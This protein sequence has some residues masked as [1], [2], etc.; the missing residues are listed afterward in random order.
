M[1]KERLTKAQIKEKLATEP[2]FINSPKHDYSLERLEVV[3][4]NGVNDR[5]A[6]SLLAISLEEFQALFKATIKKYRRLL[7]I[8]VE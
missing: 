3:N 7:K 6:S 8:D 1:K 4:P 2:D 5:F